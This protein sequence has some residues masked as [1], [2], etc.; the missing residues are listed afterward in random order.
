MFIVVV[1][2]VLYYSLYRPTAKKLHFTSGFIVKQS[3]I[4]NLPL[5]K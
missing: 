4:N 5:V 3:A 2:I 1:I